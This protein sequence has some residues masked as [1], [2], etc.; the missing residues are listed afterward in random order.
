MWTKKKHD[1]VKVSLI[2]NCAIAISSADWLP[3]SVLRQFCLQLCIEPLHWPPWFHL[4]SP[5]GHGQVNPQQKLLWW[6]SLRAYLESNSRSRGEIPSESFPPGKD[7]SWD[8]HQMCTSLDCQIG[9]CTSE[10][11]ELLALR[12]H[13]C[14]KEVEMYPSKRRGADYSPASPNQQIR[15]NFYYRS[16]SAMTQKIAVPE[17]CTA[18]LLLV[19]LPSI[20][21]VAAGR[22]CLH[23]SWE[24]HWFLH[25]PVLVKSN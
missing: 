21:Q 24:A 25:S 9:G 2:L 5:D 17:N 15:K 14:K 7:S 19:L 10:Q 8:Q 11:A 6:I 4:N 12:R 18:G 23:D 3:L 16:Q 13:S 22:N 1:T 20:S